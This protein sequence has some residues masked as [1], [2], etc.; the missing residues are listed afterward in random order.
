MTEFMEVSD[1][2][3]TAHRKLRLGRFSRVQVEVL[4]LE[5]KSNSVECD[6]LMRPSDP[7]DR[8]VPKRVAEEH[9]TLQALEDAIRLRDLVFRCFPKVPTA[10]L[11]MFRPDANHGLDLVMMGTVN[12]SNEVMG[13]VASLIMRA[14]LCGFRFNL[15]G[16]TLESMHSVS[17]GCL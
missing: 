13:R 12:R 7:W 3:R 11:R 1:F 8:D 9:M 2:L 16:G 5:W 4:R 17:F 6:W 15:Q 10:D 14:R